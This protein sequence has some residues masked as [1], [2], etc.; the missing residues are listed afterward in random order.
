LPAENYP[1]PY[2]VLVL[3]LRPVRAIRRI[4]RGS[5]TGI[6][7]SGAYWRAAASGSAG[8]CRPRPPPD[9]GRSLARLGRSGLRADPRARPP[10]AP[11]THGRPDAPPDHL[12]VAGPTW[13]CP[14]SR[15]SASCRTETPRIPQKRA[16]GLTLRTA[17]RVRTAK[18]STARAGQPALYGNMPVLQETSRRRF[19]A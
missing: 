16:A 12:T 15:G 19:W 9:P 8:V 14:H 2:A 17:G 5:L 7:P 18:G 4:R 3:Q 6:R 1:D 11:A 10:H 13:R